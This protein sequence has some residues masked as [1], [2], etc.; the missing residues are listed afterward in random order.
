MD[1]QAQSPPRNEGD[2][3]AEGE[4]QNSDVASSIPGDM[5]Y[6]EMEELKIRIQNLES[7]AL[8]KKE[9]EDKFNQIEAMNISVPILAERTN[10]AEENLGGIY[11]KILNMEEKVETINKDQPPD[12]RSGQQPRWSTSQ[13]WSLS[14]RGS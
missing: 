10:R 14:P 7:Q 1:P 4:E 5:V 11:Q 6:T 3:P 13:S 8:S 9:I 2:S 12:M